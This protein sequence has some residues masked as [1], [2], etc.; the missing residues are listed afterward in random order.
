MAL[1][2]KDARRFPLNST[3]YIFLIFWVLYTFR[4]LYDT[5]YQYYHLTEAA[6][7]FW[8][9][10]LGTCFMPAVVFLKP[11]NQAQRSFALRI[12]TISILLVGFLIVFFFKDRLGTEFSRIR[13]TEAGEVSPLLAAYLGALLM[14]WAVWLP[15]YKERMIRVIPN[16]IIALPCLYLGYY[17]F[18]LGSSR[19]SVFSLGLALLAI[20]WGVLKQRRW[21]AFAFYIPLI[22]GGIVYGSLLSVEMGGSLIERMGRMTLSYVEGDRANARLLLWEGLGIHFFQLH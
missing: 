10:A 5:F 2:V 3:L 14:S 22:I 13:G 20:L 7:R 16:I 4:L 21:G 11:M 12:F 6:W 1:F 17:C 19:G 9:Y 18:V 8:A 15:L